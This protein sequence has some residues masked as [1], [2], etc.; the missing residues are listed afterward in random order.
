MKREWWV[1]AI[2]VGVI[3]AFFA[4][5]RLHDS[6][7]DV[8]MTDMGPLE[9]REDTT[10]LTEPV[11]D[12]LVD[13]AQVLNDRPVP[14]VADNAAVPI[15]RIVGAGVLIGNAARVLARLGAPADLPAQGM[16]IEAPEDVTR[17]LDETEVHERG[18]NEVIGAWIARNQP[19]LD[20]LVATSRRPAFWTP[21]VRNEQAGLLMPALP[22]DRLVALFDALATRAH[23]ERAQGRLADGWRDAEALLR[24]CVLLETQSGAMYRFVVASIHRSASEWLQRLLEEDRPDEELTRAIIERLASLPMVRSFEEDLD[25]YERYMVLDSLVRGAQDQ[26][27]EATGINPMLR[28][29][30]WSFDEA[31]ARLE[32]DPAGVPERLRAFHQAQQAR[33]KE[34]G[35]TAGTIKQAA[36]AVATRGASASRAAGEV[37]AHTALALLPSVVERLRRVEVWRHTLLL[38]A[39][40]R[41]HRL[42]T[43]G[44]PGAVDELVP[45][46]IP[47]LPPLRWGAADVSYE[48]TEDGCRVSDG[49]WAITLI[50]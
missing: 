36:S 49:E 47:S 1:L 22:V 50:R 27:Q 29:I 28:A 8:D 23:I 32:G 9:I 26:A 16:L 4:T 14:T 15:L 18:D 41:L 34:L 44:F 7:S 30:N 46:M 21:I 2:V 11:V 35:S 48:R 31:L 3:G 39:G 24:L 40:L 20:A 38:A 13:Y 33:I 25:G 19:S 12:G 45:A 42:R 5:T 43:G 17:Q 6:E 37:V 10:R